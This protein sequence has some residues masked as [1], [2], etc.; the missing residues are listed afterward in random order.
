MLLRSGWFNQVQCVDKGEE[1]HFYHS[2]HLD[3]NVYV[4]VFSVC[5]MG[6]FGNTYLSA[7]SATFGFV[8]L[9]VH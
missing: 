8:P 3:R 2:H 7:R 1:W 6:F 9:P 4:C 5:K